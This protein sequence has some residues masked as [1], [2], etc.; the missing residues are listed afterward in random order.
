MCRGRWAAF[1]RWG[2]G[3]TEK[4]S[5]PSSSTTTGLAC[6]CGRGPGSHLEPTETLATHAAVLVAAAAIGR[7]SVEAAL[8]WELARVPLPMEH[9]A[10]TGPRPGPPPRRVD[11]VSPLG[12]TTPAT[13][14]ESALSPRG[15][16]G[17]GA[18]TLGLISAKG[19]TFAAQPGRERGSVTAWEW[20][21]RSRDPPGEWV[22]VPPQV[23][24]RAKD[25][26]PGA[27]GGT[28]AW[29]TTAWATSLEAEVPPDLVLSEEQ[30]LQISKE[31]VDIQITTHRLQEQHEAEIFQ[32]KSEIL[33]L[34]SRVL[35]LELHGDHTSQ[36]C[37]VPV[38]ADPMHRRA[39]A[40]ELRHKAQVPGHSDDCRLQVQPK[41]AMNPENE[42]QR[43]GNG[44]LGG[45]EQLQKQVKWALE[46][47]E[48]RQQALETRVE[49]LGRQLQGAR[50]EARAAGQQ[51]ATQ[52]VVL[53]S[54][55]GQL[56]QAE[57][58]NARLQLQL[59]KLKDEYVLRLQH[60][61]REAVEHADSAGQAPATM[62]L[63]TFLEATLEDIRAAHRSREQQLARAART[64]HKR[65]VDLSR[66]HEELLAAYR[67]P[68][69]P[70]AIFGA[71]SLDLE[72]LPVP[73][74]TDFSHR[75]DQHGGPEALLSSPQKGPGG[76]SQG[77]TSEPEGLDAASWAQIHQKLRD[78]S[79]STQAE[80]ERER[81]QLLVRATVAEEQL[82]EL[83]E[84]V[85]Q[86][87]GRYKQEIL[88]LR[89]LA[90]SGNPWKVGAVPPAKLQHPR[91]GSY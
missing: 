82:S 63:R 71:A 91:T 49:A 47:Q 69:N 57:A 30:Q 79:R 75:E 70:Q 46:R 3:G 51:L 59:K 84:Y 33:R 5:C 88:R 61:A 2:N 90:G 66:R 37:A 13:G 62:A 19:G 89:K 24:L 12:R 20:G 44:L 35:E 7:P 67:A 85:D 83:Q 27:P 64:Y 4:K 40:Q 77:G 45:Q 25:W 86:H 73:L 6:H 76:A 16:E 53:C 50:E 9:A 41:N 68:G 22:A 81:A 14:L 72:P 43:L 32:L 54:C 42:Q 21:H 31:L 11:N 10:T 17:A 52:A 87:L 34:E 23:V 78:F 74:V 29:G 58:E 36:G 39:P 55:R 15:Q 60:C 65:L 56:R 1:P 26:L 18:C 38:E 8:G 28:T 80:L 48:A